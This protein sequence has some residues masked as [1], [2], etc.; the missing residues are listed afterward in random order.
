MC[1]L[2]QFYIFNEILANVENHNKSTFWYMNCNLLS[3]KLS[4]ASLKNQ[5]IMMMMMMIM[6]I[7]NSNDNNYYNDDKNN[8]T[9]SFTM[10]VDKASS[11]EELCLLA[12]NCYTC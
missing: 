4:K 10:Q 2:F 5:I 11:D 9:F 6:I 3:P 7:N 1:L 12:R 8:Y